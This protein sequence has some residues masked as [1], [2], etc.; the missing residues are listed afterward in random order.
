MP[1]PFRVLLVDDHVL[2]RRGVRGTLPVAEFSVV[3]EAETIRE[4]VELVGGLDVAPDVLL[5]DY[6]LPDGDGIALAK[7]LLGRWPALHVVMFTA[8]DEEEIVVAA[9]QAGILGFVKK[10]EPLEVLL[11]A[12][13]TVAGGGPFLSST[14]SARLIGRL[15]APAVSAD[16]APQKKR[17]APRE[18]QVLRLIAA[19]KTTKEV[20]V[21]LDLETSTVE[22]YRKGVMKK[23]GAKNVAQLIQ[24]ATRLRLITGPPEGVAG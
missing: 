17:L 18:L 2:M 14:A 13:R 3:A 15:N 6:S 7:A 19:G 10:N 21:A 20:A 1:G 24:E 8:Y 23:L 9:L 12:L 4:C 22:G 5:V 11:H 16:F